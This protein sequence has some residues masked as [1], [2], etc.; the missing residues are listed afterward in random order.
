MKTMIPKKKKV[1]NHKIAE[2]AIQQHAYEIFLTK[3]GEP[4]HELDEGL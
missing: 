3:G 4:G 1:Q 2:K